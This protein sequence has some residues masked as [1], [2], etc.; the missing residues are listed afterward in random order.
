MNSNASKNLLSLPGHDSQVGKPR[1]LLD[2]MADNATHHGHRNAI[3]APQRTPLS[4]QG[5]YKHVCEFSNKLSMAGIGRDNVVLVMLNNGPEALTTIL[6]VMATAIAFPISPEEPYDAVLNLIEYL[7]IKALVYDS[8]YPGYVSQL[9]A[10]KQMT[11]ISIEINSVLPAGRF[12]I[13]NLPEKKRAEA[14]H[15]DDAAILTQTAGTSSK[16]RIIAGSQAS[17]FRAIDSAAEWMDLTERDRSLCVMPFSHL[18][19]LW[20]SCGPSLLRGGSV[21][22]CPGFDKFRVFDWIDNFNPTYMTAVPAIW[23]SLLEQADSFGINLQ[24][25]SLRQLITGSDKINFK[26]VQRLSEAFAL[27]VKEFYG[28]SEV[29]PMLAATVPSQEA[30]QGGAVGKPLDDWII[31][32]RDKD[33]LKLSPNI[34]GEIVAQGGL[35]NPVIKPHYKAPDIAENDWYHTGD[36]GFIDNQGLLHV[37]GR[38][39]ERITRGGKKF[40]PNVTEEYLESHPN[41]AQAIVFPVPDPILGERVAALVILK[42]ARESNEL[43]LRGYLADKISNFMVPD[44]ILFVEQFPTTAT[45]KLSRQSL[46]AHFQPLLQQANNSAS[47]QRTIPLSPTEESLRKMIQ[48]LLEQ[49]NIP[50]DAEFMEIGGDSFLATSLLMSIEEQFNILLSPGQFLKNSS[51]EKLAILVTELGQNH[52][53][54][55]IE[56]LQEGNGKNPLIFAH[57]VN[58]NSY[59]AHVI[60]G[61]LETKQTVFGL[62]YY[63]D[64]KN[65]IPDMTRHGKQ[66][67]KAIKKHQPKGPYRLAGYS[68]GAHLAYEIARQL[69]G[70]GDIVAFLGLIDDEADLFKRKFGISKQKLPNNSVATRCKWMLDCHVPLLYP[71][72]IDLFIGD[73]SLLERAADPTLGWQDLCIGKVKCHSINGDHISILEP[74]NVK[75]WSNLFIKC[76]E[77][78][79]KL[80][81]SKSVENWIKHS[82]QL[83]RHSLNKTFTA[84]ITARRAGRQG[85]LKQEIEFY[86]KA[87]QSNPKQ[88]YWVYRNLGDCLYQNG[89]I[90]NAEKLWLQSIDRE[91]VAVIG[92]IL[93]S[94][95]YFQSGKRQSANKHMAEAER[96]AKDTSPFLVQVAEAWLYIDQPNDA[97]RCAERALSSTPDYAYGMMILAKAFAEQKQ[98]EPA[99]R[100]AHNA[101]AKSPNE[102]GIH[103]RLSEIYRKKGDLIDA[104]NQIIKALKIADNY[105]ENYHQLSNIYVQM[106]YLE[107][108]YQAISQAIKLE[109]NLAEYHYFCS[110]IQLKQN[111]LIKSEKSLKRAIELKSDQPDYFYH[112]SHIQKRQNNFIEATRAIQNAVSLAP[113]RADFHYLYSQLLFEQNELVLSEKTIRQAIKFNHYWPELYF[114]LSEILRQKKQIVE[115]IQAIQN[116][117]SLAPEQADFHY[118][119]SQLLFE[120]DELSLSEKAIRQAIKFNQHSPEF[121]YLLSMVLEKQYRMEDAIEAMLNAINLAPKRANFHHYLSVLLF[122]QGKLRAAEFEI[123]HSIF[124]DS[125]IAAPYRHLSAILNR[126]DRPREAS[127]AINTAIQLDPKQAEYYHFRSILLFKQNKMA[128]AESAIRHSIQ[129]NASSSE[130]YQHLSKILYRMGR[131]EEAIEAIQSAIELKPGNAILFLTLGK[132]YIKQKKLVRAK[133]SFYQA[134]NLNNNFT[135]AHKHLSV[136]VDMLKKSDKKIN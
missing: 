31:E 70:Q 69:A 67:V 64:N 65:V 129:L 87:I 35:V 20:R 18:H 101:L 88:P 104:E 11:A 41:I 103:I 133:S 134:I 43:E 76:F 48:E 118:M 73:F 78:T 68:F 115:A 85:E 49:E 15:I 112:L 114:H 82:R 124:I 29:C 50:L 86:Q 45:G 55:L 93:L 26:S 89:D 1:L 95:F 39:D 5:L 8:S 99:I 77:A 38:V 30:Q 110:I 96:L 3:E 128:A 72:N 123:K 16:R 102:L 9:I 32:I 42:Q 62:N 53:P 91:K 59:Y 14:V 51:I 100:L 79:D 36:T 52:R 61:Y 108:A 132:I 98:F 2:W 120:Q 33:N 121:Y 74:K 23:N 37:T 125:Q 4:H 44:R 71:G 107:K 28:M 10:L 13:P 119:H 34:E 47:S 113:E 84:T 7:P 81:A 17:L 19:S 106:N 27:P 127:K 92:N 54:P 130:T 97:Q 83:T 136:V 21:V 135:E 111:Q 94:K 58:G 75:R 60:V 105:A 22:C 40:S 109:P 6:S 80:L 12:E 57:G 24:K 117:I 122:K 63:E 126:L 66:Y 90:A 131:Y 116:A 46:A 25:T 56:T